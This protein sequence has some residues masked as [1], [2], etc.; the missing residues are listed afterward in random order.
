M[1][2][3]SLNIRDRTVVEPIA[4]K[5]SAVYGNEK[6]FYD[7]WS[8]Q[9]CEE[10]TGKNDK[11]LAK[12]EFFFFFVSKNSLTSDL[13]K[14]EWQNAIYK[15]TDNQAQIIPVK[16]DDCL[17]PAILLQTLYIDMFGTG[18]DYG[19]RQMIDVINKKNT[20]KLVEKT[21]ENV[22]GHKIL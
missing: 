3:L 10:I 16:L 13:I 14:L 9:P 7:G 2:F 6:V 20:L 5:L 15:A 4:I 22:R 18:V 17:M 19:L 21:Y 12:C 11:V 8:S 1:I